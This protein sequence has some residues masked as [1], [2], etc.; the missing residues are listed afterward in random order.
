MAAEKNDRSKVSES[1]SRNHELQSARYVKMP[2]TTI[3][4]TSVRRKSRVA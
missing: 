3:P 1:R 4:C 2:S